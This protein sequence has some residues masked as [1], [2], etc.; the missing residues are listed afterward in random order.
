MAG[1]VVYETAKCR[2]SK[3][4]RDE[5]AHQIHT[6]FVFVQTSGHTTLF[7][8]CWIK[9]HQHVLPVFVVESLDV[10]G[11]SIGQIEQSAAVIPS[12]NRIIIVLRN[13][14][15]TARDSHRAAC[16]RPFDSSSGCFCKLMRIPADV[17]GVKKTEKRN[18][19]HTSTLARKNV[20]KQ[21]REAY[22]NVRN[23]LPYNGFG[24]V[25]ILSSDYP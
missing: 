6:V 17:I 19:Q 24:I 10:K 1:H 22:F 13:A 9:V 16:D 15:V 14:L 25:M 12:R 5:C 20:T 2:Y 4:C 21:K 18:D 23:V 7:R 11:I 8:R 3:N